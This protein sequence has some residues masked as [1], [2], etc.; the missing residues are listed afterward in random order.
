MLFIS[1]MHISNKLYHTVFTGLVL[2]SC[3]VVP[4]CS[5]LKDWDG[6]GARHSASRVVEPPR[7]QGP[8]R[9]HDSEHANYVPYSEEL[10]S[11]ENYTEEEKRLLYDVHAHPTDSSVEKDMAFESRRYE[12]RYEP[13]AVD[14]SAD[15]P[16][17]ERVARLERSMIALQDNYNH[18]LPMF[19]QL[20]TS[21]DRILSILNSTPGAGTPSIA[22]HGVNK[23]SGSRKAVKNSTAKSTSNISASVRKVRL[24]EYP[25]KTRL[26]LDVSE[27]MPF[28]YEVDNQ[29]NLLL[30]SLPKADWGTL[31]EK[32]V[33]ASSMIASYSYQPLPS[34][35]VSLAVQ[36]NR[37]A[38]VEK[39]QALP[40]LNNQVGPRIFFDISGS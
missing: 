22:D 12:P 35:G 1:V 25:N 24:G 34:G 29:E 40:A 7:F 33:N 17:E 19:Q 11:G 15:S 16:V 31:K 27:K 14:T 2:L 23:N 3:A 36:L 28:S 30:I 13:K 21:N 5:W 20:K 6:Q 8:A 37:P 18:M 26:V 10:L 39:A 9:P 38:F 4:G 32:I